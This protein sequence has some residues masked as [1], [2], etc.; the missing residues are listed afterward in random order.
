MTTTHVL[1]VND[2]NFATEVLESDGPVLIDFSAQW[3]PPC[4]MVEPLVQKVARDRAGTL[5]VVKIDIEES[6]GVATQ[7]AV[8]GAPTF[9]LVHHGREVRR[10]VGALA[11]RALLALV[12]G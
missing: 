12:D 5:K 2:L 9:V 11:E 10:R 1:Q 7:L 8:R 6:P 3:C 4:K